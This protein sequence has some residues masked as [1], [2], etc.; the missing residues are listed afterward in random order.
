LGLH[1]RSIS[2]L[3]AMR[4][5]SLPA[6]HKHVRVLESA[7]MIVRKKVGRTN[8]LALNRVPL[9]GIQD[10]LGGFNTFWGSEKETLENYAQYL[11]S[12]QPE[13]EGQ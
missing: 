6:I 11:G 4:S 5:L 3:A 10:W 2:Q 8:F 7:E 9:R 12:E 13:K 1:P